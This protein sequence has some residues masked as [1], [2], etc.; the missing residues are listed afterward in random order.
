MKS[1]RDDDTHPGFYVGCYTNGLKA[2]I[3]LFLGFCLLVCVLASCATGW[4]RAEQPGQAEATGAAQATDEF[5]QTC[6]TRYI[7]NVRTHNGINRQEIRGL[8]VR[9]APVSGRVVGSVNSNSGDLHAV[10][11]ASGWYRLC[12]L[13]PQWI[14]GD[15]QFVVVA[16]VT[17]SPAAPTRTSGPTSAP[18]TA[19]VTPTRIITNTAIPPAERTQTAQQYAQE[20]CWIPPGSPADSPGTC[21]LLPFG[22]RFTWR[23]VQIQP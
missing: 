18:P 20:L 2:T 8:N 23:T 1:E 3:A 9:L 13:T 4:V 22:S 17:P 6:D 11:L 16:T 10:E 14:S 12:S 5:G 7:V 21:S 19:A 15:A